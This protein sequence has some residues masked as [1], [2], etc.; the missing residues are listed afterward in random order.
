MCFRAGFSSSASFCAIMISSVSIVR[1]M[2]FSVDTKIS[3]SFGIMVLFCI[4]YMPSTGI[5]APASVRWSVFF[6]IVVMVPVA[7]GWA[8]AVGVMK[9]SMAFM[10]VSR[11]EIPACA[12]M[13][14]EGGMTTGANSAVPWSMNNLPSITFILVSLYKNN[15]LIASFVF[16]KNVVPL[17]SL[18]FMLVELGAFSI[19]AVPTSI[20]LSVVVS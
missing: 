6:S 17:V 5:Y 9:L 16:V 18:P 10:G 4:S 3:P 15:V 20:T 1:S 12:G 14:V 11:G 8:I 13:T 7:A 19:N 2:L